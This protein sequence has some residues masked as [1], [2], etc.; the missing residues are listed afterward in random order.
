MENFFAE[1]I[2]SLLHIIAVLLAAFSP[3]IIG[4][5]LA[6]LLN[7]PVEWVRQR[8]AGP[9]E[10]LGP[11]SPKGR[12]TAMLIT[13]TAVLLII[14]AILFAFIVLI[15]GAL[16]SGGIYETAQKV[17]LYFED[18]YR[19]IETFLSGLMPSGAE[20]E[21]NDAKSFLSGWIATNL[22]LDNLMSL[23]GA[24]TG[25]VINLL[26]GFVASIYLLKDKEFFISLWQ[27]LLSVVLKQKTHGII[28]ETLDD[29][30]NVITTFIKGALVDSLIVALLYS[31]VLSLIGVRFA[32]VIGILGGLL[33]IIP[34][35]GPFFGMVPAFLT[36]FVSGGL[37]QAVLSVLAL[38]GIQQVDSNYI[39]PKIVGTTMG[40][41]PLFVLISVS[42]LGYFAGIAGMLVAVPIAGILQVLIK[43][44]AFK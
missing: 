23:V 17:S 6:Y 19:S 32:V 33:N 13:Y 25:G 8:L 1:I 14:A 5:I 42:V 12:G 27:R 41:H 28:N 10:L 38:L 40:L 39:Y 43:K 30:N 3:L 11:Q 36:A 37:W 22:S 31:L 18:S 20:T 21:M 26:I 7:T 9:H 24:I 2:N 15:L 4:L 44:W 29:I 16:P 34:Y 35:F